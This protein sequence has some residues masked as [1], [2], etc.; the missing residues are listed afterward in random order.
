MFS[1]AACFALICV[2]AIRL[3]MS[4]LT[5]EKQSPRE[6]IEKTVSPPPR[7]SMLSTNPPPQSGRGASEAD[8]ASRW[9]NLGTPVSPELVSFQRF[10]RESGNPGTVLWRQRCLELAAQDEQTQRLAINSVGK[11]EDRAERSRAFQLVCEAAGKSKRVVLMHW[12][13][14]K[15]LRPLSWQEL[16]NDSH[17]TQLAALVP[18]ARNNSE[19]R[20]ICQALVAFEQPQAIDLFMSLVREP[21]WRQPIRRAAR[22]LPDDVVNVLIQR[23]RS[24]RS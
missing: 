3:G 4:P 23:M 7:E 14:H 1:T 17:L 5:A 9:E 20:Q 18:I 13:S 10:V 22:Q 19:R 16:V 6:Q 12:L 11:L 8:K 24:S 2:P 15:E 21:Q